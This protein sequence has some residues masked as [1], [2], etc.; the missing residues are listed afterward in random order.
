[1]AISYQHEHI[2]TLNA[3]TALT[4]P[5][6]SERCTVYAVGGNVR[7]MLDGTAPTTSSGAVLADTKVT[8]LSLEITDGETIQHARF[9]KNAAEAPQAAELADVFCRT[10][11]R[12]IAAHFRAVR[13]NDDVAKYATAR[14]LLDGEHLWLERG[15][16]PM[17][18]AAELLAEAAPAA[19]GR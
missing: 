9:I 15:M 3:S 4:P 14:R 6:G 1:M 2:A 18:M 13:A 19:A 5:S 11:R 8:G 17:A 12:R 10:T 16:T 7:F